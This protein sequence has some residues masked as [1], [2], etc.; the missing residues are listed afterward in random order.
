MILLYEAHKTV[1]L[2]ETAS[3]VVLNSICRDINEKYEVS[4]L[5]MK[6]RSS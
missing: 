1:K 4:S 2:I 6:D 5:V 3:R